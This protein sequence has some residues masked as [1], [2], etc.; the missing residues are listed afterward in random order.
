[1]KLALVGTG[2]IV[3]EVLP[4][5]KE[6]KSIDLMAIVSTPRSLEIAEALADAFGIQQASCQL[7][8]VLKNE[9]VDTVYVAIPNHLHFEVAKQALEAGKHVICEKPFT[10]TAKE[11][12][13]LSSIA[14]AKQL[15]LL[16]AITNQYLPNTQFIK[17]HLTELGDIKLVE[18]NYSQYS[19]RYDAFQRGEIAPAFDPKKGGGALRDLNIYNIHLLVG[20]FG[21][22]KTVQYLANMERQVDTSGVLLMDYERFK[23]VCIGAKDCSAEIVSTIQGNKGFLSV[24]GAPN[25]VPELLLA[26]RGEQARTVNLNHSSH[27]MY[28]EFVAF[29][30]IISNKNMERAEQALEHSKAVMAVLEQAAASL[31]S[32]S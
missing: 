27:R 22:P 19:S 3:K 29:S 20:L 7:A 28:D 2:M 12:D 8:E 15:I 25:A 4:V 21:K 32:N 16:E 24:L 6:I 30:D 13:T 26:I 1:M 5:L 14:R 18:C 17:E 23:A 9:E 31:E 11:L 10:M